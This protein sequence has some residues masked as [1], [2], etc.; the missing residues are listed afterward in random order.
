MER[1]RYGSGQDTGSRQ[2][3]LPISGVSR[4]RTPQALRCHPRTRHRLLEV[5]PLRESVSPRNP[6]R[7][8]GRTAIGDTC[9]SRSQ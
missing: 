7:H 1:S 6:R 9:G 5:M 2:R 4:D 8:S 3:Y